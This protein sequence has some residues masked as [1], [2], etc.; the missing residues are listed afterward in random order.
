MARIAV[1]G[2]QAFAL[3]NF[4]MALLGAMA[5]AGHEVVAF[6]PDFTEADRAALLAR[7]IGAADYLLE[8]N[9]L[10]LVRDLQTLRDLNRQLRQGAFDVVFAFTI[11]P[12]VYG[13]LAAA[14]ASVPRRFALITGLGYTLAQV[15]DARPKDRLVGIAAKSLYRLALRFATGAFF[16][17]G[18]DRDTFVR[19]GLVADEK[20]LGVVPTGVDLDHWKSAPHVTE[21]MTFSL[22]GRMLVDKGVREFASAARCL[23]ASYPDARFVLI[24]GLDS[25]PRALSRTQ[26][27]ELVEDGTV[28]WTGHV[29]V[30]EWLERTSVFVLPSYH[31]G[32][33]RSTQE[34]MAMARPVVTTDVP[35]CRDTVLEGVNGYLV[36]ARDVDA[37]AKAMERFISSPNLVRQ[38]G[39]QSRALA[40]E[41]F[42]VHKANARLLAAMNL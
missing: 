31:E 40:E 20:V 32:V 7:G 15:D 34:A 11:K 14:M 5:D 23:K 42:S 24:G 35:G 36:P 25:N 38:M 10:N 41:R 12:V 27:E 39:A 9:G 37:L 8:R 22:V 33:P 28:V 4:R 19:L 29:D 30:K 13:I 2:S 3:L 6:V 17:N 26:M 16:Q 1:I 18:D 21:P